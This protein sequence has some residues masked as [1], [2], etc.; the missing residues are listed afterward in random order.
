[1]C[2]ANVLYYTPKAK[3]KEHNNSESYI[4][5]TVLNYG[6]YIFST[7]RVAMATPGNT[8]KLIIC[9]FILQSHLM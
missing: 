9:L 5:C 6:S 7:F 2:T 3:D 1:M 8:D 4:I